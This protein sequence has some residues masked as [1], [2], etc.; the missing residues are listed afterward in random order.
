MRTIQV[1]TDVFA[2]IWAARLDGEETEDQ[3]LG[4]LLGCGQSIATA[5]EAS[6]VIHPPGDGFGFYDA[7]NDVEFA[8]GFEIYRRYKGKEFS[9]VASQGSWRRSDSGQV[10][11][12]LNQ[13]NQSIVAGQENV[14]NGNWFYRLNGKELPI[15]SLRGD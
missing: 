8:E 11:P 13:L 2:A 7:R 10:F 9:A 3:I 5:T 6:A 12:S 1:R 4:R 14:W 15:S